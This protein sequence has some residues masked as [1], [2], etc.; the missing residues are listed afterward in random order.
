MPPLSKLKKGRVSKTIWDDLGTT[1]NGTQ[2]L[3]SIFGKS[4]F[5]N[6]KPEELLQ[7]IIQIPFSSFVIIRIRES[8]A[9]LF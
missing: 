3:K 5:D 4:I 9:V 1:T 8:F 6:P 2:H 7:R